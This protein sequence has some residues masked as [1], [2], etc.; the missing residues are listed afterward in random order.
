MVTLQIDPMID[1]V[2]GQPPSP[3][4]ESLVE[5][6]RTMPLHG[7]L[8]IAYPI[9][10]SLDRVKT[11]DALLTCSEHGVVAFD[12]STHRTEDGDLDH[13]RVQDVQDEIFLAL[14]SKFQEHPQLRHRRQL[15]FSIAVTTFLPTTPKSTEWA[16]LDFVTPDTVTAFI[17]R[18]DHLPDGLLEPLNAVIQ[19][20]AALRPKKRRE[21][22][23]T[24]QSLGGILK[25]IER[26]IANLDQWQKKAAIAY[27]GGPQRIRGLAGSGKTIVLAQKASFLHAQYPDWNIAVTFYTRSLYQQFHTLIRRFYFELMNDDPDWQRLQVLHSWGSSSSPGIYSKLAQSRGTEVRDFGYAKTR[28]GQENAFSGICAEV[29]DAKDPAV[30]IFDAVLIDEA[31]DFPTEF[32]QLVYHATRAPKRVVWAYDELQN[33]GDYSMAPAETL[34]GADDHNQ[35]RVSLTNPSHGLQQDIVLP[36]CYRNTPWALTVAHSLGFGIYRQDGIVQMFDDLNLWREIGYDVVSGELSPGRLVSLSRRSGGSPGYF[37]E[38]LTP[39]DAVQCHVFGSFLKECE[40]VAGSIARNLTEDELDHDDI[41]I[42]YVEPTST[43][44]AAASIAKALLSKGIDSHL[45]RRH[46]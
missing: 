9:L 18:Q 21:N 13:S 39:Q 45:G 28:Y 7:S 37:K 38:L 26:E 16:D 32:F 34:F 11:L 3:I 40:W 15:A 24:T 20:T 43:K 22:V 42:I 27:P 44:R 35:P 5:G 41:L 8:Y 33:L 6:L 31:Q 17:S 19:R 2:Y 29:L 4:V 30:P 23:S 1:V 36:V 12:L 10:K 14:Q 46:D 25:R